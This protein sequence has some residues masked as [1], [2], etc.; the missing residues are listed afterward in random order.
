MEMQDW[1]ESWVKMDST[2]KQESWAQH[3]QVRKGKREPHKPGLRD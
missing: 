1:Q 3:K 2:A